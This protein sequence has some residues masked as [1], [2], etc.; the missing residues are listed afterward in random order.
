M[1]DPLKDFFGAARGIRMTEQ[2]HQ[3]GR[4]NLRASVRNSP[5][6]RQEHRM[7]EQTFFTSAKS[8]A[9]TP[10]E[11]VLGKEQLVAFMASSKRW[12]LHPFKGF[13]SVLASILI[14][15][16][17]GTSV[18]YA[19][20]SAMPGDLLYPVKMHVNE[21]I[22]MSMA[23]TPET[24]AKVAAKHAET[25]LHEAEMLAQNSSLGMETQKMLAE[26]IQ[27]NIE[28]VQREVV[29]LIET[30]DVTAAGSIGVSLE[31]TIGA[32]T[33]L[34]ARLVSEHHGN[35]SDDLMKALHASRMS[36]EETAIVA[37][38]DPSI[39]PSVVAA[40]RAEM[41][42]VHGENGKGKDDDMDDDL[43][44]AEDALTG[45]D[46]TGMTAAKKLR[47]ARTALRK[48]KEAA[49]FGMMPDTPQVT[50]TAPA[51]MMMK[52]EAP[53][54]IEEEESGEESDD[55]DL[56]FDMSVRM[57]L[58]N[59]RIENVREKLDRHRG[60][61]PEEKSHPVETRIKGSKQLMDMAKMHMDEGNDEE[62][63]DASDA[64]LRHANEA[65]KELRKLMQDEE[66]DR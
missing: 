38:T 39:L 54:N 3:T 22:E 25:R 21:P 40:A 6:V 65:T 44:S 23:R 2:E 45:V 13:T 58:T 5:D 32:H 59:D 31:A 49:V 34:L 64:A 17:A 27:R 56:R 30:E 43:A 19:A 52:A 53:E 42:A 12:W 24:R 48:A 55:D 41:H 36:M 8:I 47:M 16:I 4:A 33:K 10:R 46:G 57:H 14:V 66:E 7:D 35:E 50:A 1:T 51:V 60:S 9:L 15:C 63:L 26:E 18:S 20:E 37:N 11:H 29:T 28:A 61:M 62:A